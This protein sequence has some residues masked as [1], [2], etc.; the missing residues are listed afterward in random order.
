MASNDARSLCNGQ[1]PET[2]SFS[3]GNVPPAAQ[4]WPVPGDW[5]ATGN[6]RVLDHQLAQS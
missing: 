3:N 5:Y 6:P 4:Y 2:L 1:A